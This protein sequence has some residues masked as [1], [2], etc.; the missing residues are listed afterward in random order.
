LLGMRGP[1][2]TF[3]DSWVY[4]GLLVL[5]SL[6]CLARGFA[7]TTERLPWL[8]LGI[9]LA[10]WTTGDLYYYFPFSGLADLPVPSVS[11]PFYLASYPVRYVPL[12]LLLRRSMQR[13]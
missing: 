5:A 12:A 9:S 8:L 7:D 10:L 13:F 4:N 3:F 11:D 1:V 2:D 6:A